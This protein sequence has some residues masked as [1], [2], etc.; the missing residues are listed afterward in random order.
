MGSLPDEHDVWF[1]DG[2]PQQVQEF[3]NQDGAV[4]YLSYVN[5]EPRRFVSMQEELAVS[6]GTLHDI[7]SEAGGLGLRRVGQQRYEET[8][9]RVHELSPMGETVVERM[10]EIGVTQ[11][12]TRLRNIRSEYEL[13]KQEYLDWVND[14]EDGVSDRIEDFVEVIDEE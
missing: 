2:Y 11:L 6:D 5:Q 14:D 1:E 3:L 9:Y 13:A 12:H 10:Q 8:V 4:E 7:H